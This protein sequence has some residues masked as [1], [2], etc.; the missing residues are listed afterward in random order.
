MIIGNY[1]IDDDWSFWSPIMYK[2]QVTDN[3]A[4]HNILAYYYEGC[5]VCDINPRSLVLIHQE[6]Y[7]KHPDDYLFSSLHEAQEHVDS[8]LLKLSKLGAFL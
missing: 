2:K 4:I 6:M 7:N 1:K 8:F 3:R 5:Y